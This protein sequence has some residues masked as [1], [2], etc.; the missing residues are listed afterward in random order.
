MKTAQEKFRELQEK[1]KKIEQA[2]IQINTKIESAREAYQKLA[3]LAKEKYKTSDINELK[4]I[5]Q[6]WQE[7]NEIQIKKYQEAI[8]KLEQEV[9]EKNDLIRQIQQSIS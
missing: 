7:E 5:L 9:N 3:Q 2:A 8:E 6:Q 4:K 1:G